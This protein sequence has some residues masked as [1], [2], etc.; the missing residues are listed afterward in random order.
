MGGNKPILTIIMRGTAVVSLLVAA[1]VMFV[2]YQKVQA[3]ESYIFEAKYYHWNG[4]IC[5]TV[6]NMTFVPSINYIM[7]YAVISSIGCIYNLGILF[8]PSGSQLW[9]TIILLD[10]ILNILVGATSLGAAWQT[11]FLVKD[12]SIYVG[13]APLCGVVPHF[14]SKILASLI[15]STLG[16]S[17]TFALLMCTLHVGVDPFLVDG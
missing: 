10:V 17:F 4:F 6:E 11:Y 12:G 2:S 13:W 14:C 1:I 16:Y 15:T 7:F 9:K 8:I 3:E 5:I